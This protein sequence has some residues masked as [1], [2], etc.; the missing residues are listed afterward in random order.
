MSLPIAHRAQVQDQ[1]TTEENARAREGALHPNSWARRRN[2]REFNLA[3]EGRLSCATA[4]R[5]SEG[6]LIG[7]KILG[8]YV[9]KVKR[10]VASLQTLRH[11]ARHSRFID[12]RS[13][14]RARAFVRASIQPSDLEFSFCVTRG[15]LRF[16]NRIKKTIFFALPAQ[17]SASSTIYHPK[18]LSQGSLLPSASQLCARLV[19]LLYR[20]RIASL[21]LQKSL[22]A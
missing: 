9:C 5:T 22:E 14:P 3:G 2:L 18:L 21:E 1:R 4:S 8:D 17:F 6:I 16:R 13:A 15:T 11:V 20:C 7:G 10:S 12:A 19:W